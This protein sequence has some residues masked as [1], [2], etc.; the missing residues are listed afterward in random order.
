MSLFKGLRVRMQILGQEA[1]TTLTKINLRKL[2]LQ[3]GR[4]R[5]MGDRYLDFNLICN[6]EEVMKKKID[7]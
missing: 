3:L 6:K 2:L 1:E 7:P 4:G 5:G